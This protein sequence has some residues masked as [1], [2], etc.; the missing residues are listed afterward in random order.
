MKKTLSLV[1]TA[2]VYLS[3]LSANVEV[4]GKIFFESETVE[5][6]FLIPDKLYPSK[7]AM[8]IAMGKN[9]MMKIQEEIKYIDQD[10][11]KKWLK[12]TEAKGIEFIY[13]GDTIVMMSKGITYKIFKERTDYY[14]LELAS[15]GKINLYNFYAMF[16]GKNDRMD[17]SFTNIDN[18]L[19]RGFGTGFSHAIINFILEKESGD[20]LYLF[21]EGDRIENNHKKELLEFLSDC[22]AAVSKIKSKKLVKAEVQA[23]MDAYN[24]NDCGTA[25]PKEEEKKIIE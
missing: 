20:R 8:K 3:R 7:S 17:K 1:I 16:D 14:F 22:P 4:E 11:K 5:V 24:G 25:E 13:E 18:S 9:G 2:L 12:P 23:M 10:G 21:F 19:S 6:K 15:S